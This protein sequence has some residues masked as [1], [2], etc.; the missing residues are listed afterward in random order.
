MGTEKEAP[1]IHVLSAV[2]CTLSAL[3]GQVSDTPA[4][5]A[6][7]NFKSLVGEWQGQ[8]SDGRKI[9]QR[10]K[11]IAGESVLM[12][13]S[14]FDAH[15]GE[16]MV[17]MYHLDGRRLVLTHYC[18]A[19]NQPRLAATE[20]AASGDKVLFTFLDGT[21]IPDRNKGHMDKAQYTFLNKDKFSNKWTWYQ[22]GKEQW[23]E[24]FTLQRVKP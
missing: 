1:M 15:P 5:K 14:W 3:S 18:V 24:E 8:A 19:K 4:V 9:R 16:L 17:T 21:N 13:E 12:E 10:Y 2:V 23:M 11:L 22:N 7:N 20:L 6:W